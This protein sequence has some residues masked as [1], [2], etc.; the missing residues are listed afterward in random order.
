V[1]CLERWCYLLVLIV[2]NATTFI[3]EYFQCRRYDRPCEKEAQAQSRAALCMGRRKKELIINCTEIHLLYITI[4]LART[5][6]V[7]TK[8]T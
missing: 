3:R 4:T 6:V 5:A 1:A 7:V 8:S 2:F